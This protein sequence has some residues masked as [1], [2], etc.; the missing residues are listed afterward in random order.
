MLDARFVEFL[1]DISK[2]FT[3]RDFSR[4]QARVLFPCSLVTAAGPVVLQNDADLRN[5]FD[6]YLIA[7]DTLRL[8]TIVRTPRDLED[9]KDGTWIGSYE[10]NLLSKGTRAVPPFTSSALMV[11]DNGGFKMTSILNARGHHEWTGVMPNARL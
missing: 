4:L 6:L 8:D 10:T 3:E 2:C 7:C 5:S 1:D 9:C 11:L